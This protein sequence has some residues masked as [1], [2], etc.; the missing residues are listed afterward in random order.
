M[1]PKVNKLSNNYALKECKSL[2]YLRLMVDNLL[3]FD[4]HVDY[5]EMK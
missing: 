3:K 4:I 1:L 2:K 5:I